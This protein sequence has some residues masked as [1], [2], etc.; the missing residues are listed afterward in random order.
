M[1]ESSA[2]QLGIDGEV[3]RNAGTFGS[4]TWTAVSLVRNV[5]SGMV[6][7]MA[8]A[9]IRATA[10]VLQA[11]TQV[12]IS[13]SI[14]VRA[15]PAD[16]GYQVLFDA[17]R[18]RTPADLMILDGPITQEGCKGVRGHMN[19]N[20]EQDQNIN[21]VIY[22][23]FAFSPAWHADGYPSYVEMGASSAPTFTQF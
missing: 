11:K 13:G 19:L 1:A 5:S 12:A 17:S 7:N 20:F 6:W 10:A 23:R 22:T 21:D 18:G 2:V 14:E 3:Y 15:D 8:D 4:P 9:S 16:A